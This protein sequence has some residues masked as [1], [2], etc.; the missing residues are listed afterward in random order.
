[1]IPPKS[2]SSFSNAD[3]IHVVLSFAKR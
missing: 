1:M 3:A 2:S